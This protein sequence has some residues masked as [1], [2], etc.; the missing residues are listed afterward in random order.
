MARRLDARTLAVLTAGSVR[1]GLL[2]WLLLTFLTDHN[3]RLTH[4]GLGQ[5]PNTV[6]QAYRDWLSGDAARYDAAQRARYATLRA[7]TAPSVGLLPLPVQPT[8]LFYYDISA[9]STLWG[10]Q[11][12]ARFFG[13]KAVWVQPPGTKP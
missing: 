2:G 4:A 10:N 3:A 13:K 11:A 7:T 8:T 1:A 6:V 9:N 12:Y 5:Q